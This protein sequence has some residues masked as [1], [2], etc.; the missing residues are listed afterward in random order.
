M[1]VTVQPITQSIDVRC[2]MPYWPE[3]TVYPAPLKDITI[4][5]REQASMVVLVPRNIRTA[6][7]RLPTI[8]TV[9]I[10]EA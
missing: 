9:S 10:Y 1:T 4:T 8:P 2:I 3:V 7:F 5:C 6:S